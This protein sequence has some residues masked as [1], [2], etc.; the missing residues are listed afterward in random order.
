[1]TVQVAFEAQALEEAA[2]EAWDYPIDLTVTEAG[3]W[4]KED[5]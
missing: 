5:K 2:M 4:E 3:V 1:M